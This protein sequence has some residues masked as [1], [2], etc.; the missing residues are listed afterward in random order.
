MGKSVKRGDLMH[1]IKVKAFN[2]NTKRFTV[3]PTELVKNIHEINVEDYVRN[4]KTALNQTFEPMNI[5]FSN[6]ITN[7]KTLLDFTSNRKSTN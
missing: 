7:E 1:F 4:L 6:Q 3:K 2:Y 5:T